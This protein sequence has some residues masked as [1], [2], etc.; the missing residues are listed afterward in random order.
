MTL[1]NPRQLQVTRE[2]LD[3]LECKIAEIRKKSSGDRHSEELT[4]RSL[5]Q[6]A[7]QLKEE[8]VRCEATSIL[9]DN[10]CS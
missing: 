9:S 10:S 5:R 4:L 2:K 7:N 6:L 8:I 3:L 1:S